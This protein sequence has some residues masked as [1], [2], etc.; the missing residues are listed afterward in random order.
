MSGSELVVVRHARADGNAAHRFIGWSDVGLDE[1]GGRQAL[2][3]AHRLGGTAIERIVVSDLR[4]AVETAAPLAARLKIE[5]EREPALREIDNGAWTGLLPS[6]IEAGWPE[7]WT[8]YVNGADVD[9]P[10]GERWEDVR[11]R[12]HRAMG[13]LA[14]GPT[15]LVISH[16]GPVVL[17]VEWALGT[18]FEGNIF[19]GPLAVPANAAIS[20][21]ASGPK[22]LTYNDVGHL[23]PLA[24]LDVPYAAVDR[25]EAPAP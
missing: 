15:T 13:E 3:L 10:G 7:L 2:A 9:R 23:G 14:G 21:I 16:G 22:L 17:A 20:V 19:R 4:R 11:A 25:P 6:E 5:M 12:V 1:A 8:A 18:R 24:S